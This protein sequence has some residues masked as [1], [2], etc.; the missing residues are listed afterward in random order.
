M[1][2]GPDLVVLSVSSAFRVHK[3]SVWIC[4]AAVT[5]LA[6]EASCCSRVIAAFL[7]VLQTYTHTNATTIA[8]Q[9]LS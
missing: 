9:Q 7:N 1:K 3:F 8:I 2:C 4:E 5:E 6:V